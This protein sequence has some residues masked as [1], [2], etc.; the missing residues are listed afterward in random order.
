MNFPSF[1]KAWIILWKGLSFLFEI[2]YNINNKKAFT[3]EGNSMDD[4]KC[5]IA[6]KNL[7]IL[8]TE[9]WDPR[10]MRC[11]VRLAKEGLIQPALNGSRLDISR[12]AAEYHIDIADIPIMDP[13]TYPRMDEM[14]LRM[15]ELR[16]GKL[17][18]LECCDQLRQPQYF[19]T[20]CLVMGDVDGLLGGATITTRETLRAA[21]QLIKPKENCDIV[22]SCFLM[23]QGERRFILGD[24]SL[25]IE[26]DAAQ[27]VEITIQCAKTAQMFGMTP[28]VGLLS[29][30]TLGSGSGPSVE[31]VR[32][33]VKRLK[34]L[35]LTYEVDGELQLDAALVQ[36]VALMK[37]AHSRVAGSAN[38]LIFPSL[39]AGNIGYKLMARLGGFEAV[40]PI[41][42]GLRKPLND[43][44]RGASEEEIYQLAIVTAAQA[45]LKDDDG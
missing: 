32:E 19:A 18:A 41:L 8:F 29:Y 2:R 6:G 20:M 22:S 23:K 15:V 28:R 5:R 10:M 11:A 21:L 9:G 40:G 13:S 26:P 30:S 17:S 12:Q 25:N 38:T 35:P 43:L 14:I 33:A 3:E 16:K 34:R 42:Q 7:K 24:C 4:L 45:V 36:E 39:D 37:A 1:K 31:K 27:L 44:S